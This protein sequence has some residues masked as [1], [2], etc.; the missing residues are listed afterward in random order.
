M[1]I[2]RTALSTGGSVREVLCGCVVLVMIAQVLGIEQAH[3]KE[4][5]LIAV[6]ANLR[7]A[8]QPINKAYRARGGRLPRI[9]FGSSGNLARQILRGAP[10]QLFLSAD[11]ARARLL[12]KGGKAAQPSVVYAEGR[13]AII[14][15]RSGKSAPLKS[16]RSIFK[17]YDTR[18]GLRLA[19]ANPKLAPYGVAASAYLRQA[20]YYDGLSRALVF[21][22][23]ASQVLQFVASGAAYAGLTALS[24]VSTKPMQSKFVVLVIAPESYPPIRQRMVLLKGAEPATR[25][26]FRFLQQNAARAILAR[27]GYGMPN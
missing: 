12:E 9:S 2:F 25:A 7:F 17:A 5:P 27:H 16:I 24:L 23:N 4:R 14:L 15:R 1:I 6:A 18:T 3:A 22:D 11:E 21:G 10:F 13:L 20:G 19:I 26:Y 8:I